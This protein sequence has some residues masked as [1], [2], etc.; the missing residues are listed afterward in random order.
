MKPRII[1]LTGGIG[2][3][4]ST[5]AKMLADVSVPVLDLD[6]VG[7]DC[8]H[9][10]SVKDAL[11]MQFGADI[12]DEHQ[13]VQRAK[14]AAKAFAHSQAT[15]QLNQILHPAI[16]QQEQLWIKQQSAPYVIIE[17][18]ALLES[19]GESRMD[20]VAVVL[21]DVELRR[22]RVLQRGRQDAAAFERILNIQ[23][24][25]EWRRAK[26]DYILENSRDKTALLTQVMALHQQW[27]QS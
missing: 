25:D 2:S 21:A 3:G 13:H 12:L 20:A 27:M 7:H 14:L 26:A 1:A 19:K 11:L 18:S 6:R 24:D 16:L 5:V 22:K 4:K 9:E 17:A 15:Q 23:C 8:L 10:T